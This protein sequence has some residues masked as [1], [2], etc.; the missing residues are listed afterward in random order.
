VH[1]DPQ[2]DFLILQDRER[3]DCRLLEAFFE[4]TAHLRP[5]VCPHLLAKLVLA[6]VA[7]GHLATDR[8]LERRTAETAADEGLC[9]RR[10][11]PVNFAKGLGVIVPEE[12]R[13]TA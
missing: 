10:Q 12:D 5:K 2:A 11:N 6:L 8:F 13:S 1:P 7:V 9:R 3:I 4:T